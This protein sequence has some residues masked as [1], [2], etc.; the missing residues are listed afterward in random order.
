[1]SILDEMKLPLVNPNEELEDIEKAHNQM[2]IIG[3]TR[4][5]KVENKIRKQR[6]TELRETYFI[7]LGFEYDPGSGF[8]KM[9]YHVIHLI[10]KKKK[11][12]E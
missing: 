11:K 7:P 3:E 5:S 1:M 10:K 4:A 6:G 9:N 2:L 8:N 12:N